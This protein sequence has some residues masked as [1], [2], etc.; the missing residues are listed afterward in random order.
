M[1]IPYMSSS[2][3]LLSGGLTLQ[4]NKVIKLSNRYTISTSLLPLTIFL[5]FRLM[6]LISIFLCVEKIK[7]VFL[8]L[9]GSCWMRFDFAN[10]ATLNLGVF[11]I[12]LILGVQQNFL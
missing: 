1:D 6:H 4:E 7:N 5:K 9:K 2:S 12:P 11:E 8:L 10:I 3:S